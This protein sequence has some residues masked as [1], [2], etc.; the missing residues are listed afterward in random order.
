M[1]FIV[2]FPGYLYPISDCRGAAASDAGQRA[3]TRGTVRQEKNRAKGMQPPLPA[4][5]LDLPTM[6]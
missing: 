3:E 2:I 6:I 1:I 4:G 5:V